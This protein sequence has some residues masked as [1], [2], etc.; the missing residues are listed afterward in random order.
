[1]STYQSSGSNRVL[2]WVPDDFHL[3][4]TSHNSISTGVQN[5]SIIVCIWGL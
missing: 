3:A 1:M 5:N 2:N 4:N